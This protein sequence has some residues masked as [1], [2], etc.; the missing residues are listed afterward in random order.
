[1]GNNN[2]N[3]NHNYNNN[4]N[5]NYYNNN[6]NNYN[7][8]NNNHN[9]YHNNHLEPNP[10]TDTS[11]DC[12]ARCYQRYPG[13][14]DSSAGKAEKKKPGQEAG[15]PGLYCGHQGSGPALR[16]SCSGSNFQ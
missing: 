16:S 2:N 7:N 15:L 11:P 5:N 1:M 4:Y 9:N 12:P 3:N 13:S 10:A 6:N 8:N 14:A